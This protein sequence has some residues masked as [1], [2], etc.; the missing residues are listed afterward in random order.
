MVEHVRLVDDQDGG[1]P[2]LG[3]LAG[4][5]VPGLDGEGGGA[6]D[7]LAAEGGDHVGEDAPHAGGGVAD[8]YDGV[9]GGVEAGGGGAD[10]DRLP[11]PD[12]ARDHADRLVGDGP[13][14]AGGGLAAVAAAVQPG[15]GQV[16]AERH[17]GEPEPG[18]DGVDHQ[19]SPSS[20]SC[21]DGP[22]LT[23]ASCCR[24]QPRSRARAAAV[25]RA[26]EMNS[27]APLTAPAGPG[28]SSQPSRP[29]ARADASHRPAWA[30]SW[31]S[32]AAAS[33]SSP[34]SS[35][36]SAGCSRPSPPRAAWFRERT[37]PAA[38]R[39]RARVWP[40]E[41]V[42]AFLPLVL[43]VFRLFLLLR[44]LRAAEEE[45]AGDLLAQGLVVAVAEGAQVVDPGR[46]RLGAGPGSYTHL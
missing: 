37:A 17:A 43:L 18:D 41:S 39:A 11:G 15:G 13:G 14:D 3:C 26:P 32:P 40:G 25:F 21:A 42:T 36:A 8:V 22:P 44:F 1:P 31:G 45:L 5:D 9:A 12:L 7:G 38:V 10:R 46:G 34:M 16:A 24:A 4:Q 30:S 28:P 35:Q 33:A 19:D 2:A 23:A 20:A 29:A 27:R 6:V